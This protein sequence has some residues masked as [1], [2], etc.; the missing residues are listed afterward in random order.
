MDTVSPLKGTL[1]KLVALKD[2]FEGQAS[3]AVGESSRGSSRKFIGLPV[4]A[5]VP[6][7]TMEVFRSLVTAAAPASAMVGSFLGFSGVVVTD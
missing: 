3:W 7:S 4:S 2:S 1:V 5:A 6:A